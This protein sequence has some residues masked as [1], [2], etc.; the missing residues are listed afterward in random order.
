MPDITMC[1]GEGCV[2]RT[3]CYRFC[4]I[5][6]GFQSYFAIAPHDNDECVH[7][8]PNREKIRKEDEESTELT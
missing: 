5:P 7:F 1:T 6:D 4:A 2:Q 8:W 3:K